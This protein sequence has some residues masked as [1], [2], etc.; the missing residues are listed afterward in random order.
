MWS[1]GGEGFGQINKKKM[2]QRKTTKEKGV[3]E[4]CGLWT[5]LRRST[6]T[7]FFRFL[8]HLKPSDPVHTFILHTDTRLPYFH[9]DFLVSFLSTVFFSRNRCNLVNQINTMLFWHVTCYVLGERMPCT[10][11]GKPQIC[12]LLLPVL[13]S[14]SVPFMAQKS[15]HKQ[16]TSFRSGCMG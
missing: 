3:F 4:P 14:K 2:C 1:F 13:L 16:Y 5:V 10:F 11:Q 9:S 6:L 7:W 8:K 15:K 12:W